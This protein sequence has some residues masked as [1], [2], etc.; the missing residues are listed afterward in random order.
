M[1]ETYSQVANNLTSLIHYSLEENYFNNYIRNIE[2]C[3]KQEIEDVAKKK[4][5]SD[6]LIYLIVG[7]REIIRPQLSAFTDQNIVELDKFGE[8]INSV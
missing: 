4:I 6:K 2:S 8:R 5:I 3:T 1:F 7:D